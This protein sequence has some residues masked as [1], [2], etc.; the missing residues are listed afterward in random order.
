MEDKFKKLKIRL[1]EL[2]WPQ[3]Y[4][5]KFICPSDPETIAK[6]TALLNDS[7]EDLN[8]RPSRK[9][10]YVSISAKEVMTSASAVI[11]VYEESAKIKGVISL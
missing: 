8:I 10:N 7:S 3:V 6:V 5:F 11:E 9:G 2:T 1:E 4:Y